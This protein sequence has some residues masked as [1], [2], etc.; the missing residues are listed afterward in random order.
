MTKARNLRDVLVLL[1]NNIVGSKDV[2]EERILLDGSQVTKKVCHWSPGEFLQKTL[3]VNPKP[4][5]GSQEENDADDED[6]NPFSLK[7]FVDSVLSQAAFN[8][9]ER[10]GKAP[11]KV[12]LDMA[13]S[14][15]HALLH[16]PKIHQFNL[17]HSFL[18]RDFILTLLKSEDCVLVKKWLAES[19]D[20]ESDQI[21]RMRY[22]HGQLGRS[23]KFGYWVT[24]IQGLK[25]PT[26]I[27]A[28]MTNI[29]ISFNHAK[30]FQNLILRHGVVKEGYTTNYPGAAEAMVKELKLTPYMPFTGKSLDHEDFDTTFIN[31]IFLQPINTIGSNGGRILNYFLS[32]NKEL[33]SKNKVDD[34]RWGWHKHR[35]G[36]SL[37]F[38]WIEVLHIVGYHF[39]G[40]DRI[41]SLAPGLQTRLC[42][43]KEVAEEGKQRIHEDRFLE[44]N[45][46]RLFHVSAV[47]L[48]G[49]ALICHPRKSCNSLQNFPSGFL[50]NLFPKDPRTVSLCQMWNYLSH[51][52]IQGS[53]LEGILT[54]LTGNKS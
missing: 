30:M 53:I 45:G 19:V 33:K 35:I 22:H 7:E 42:F 3:N 10:K 41:S 4:P 48:V 15:V 27:C 44:N 32:K 2:E 14:L 34:Y 25:F 5:E 37:N 51:C 52:W 9:K 13:E 17:R 49:F 54:I 50:I 18:F 46:G 6:N 26:M 8:L 31:N 20:E 12:I 38:Q 21:M 11:D 28:M 1:L 23:Q 40:T 36:F 43:L 39:P 29:C 47:C 16:G 24:K